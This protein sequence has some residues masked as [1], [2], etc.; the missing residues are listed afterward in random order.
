M[1][2]LIM[3]GGKGGCLA[4]LVADAG[5]HVN[6]TCLCAESRIPS[7]VLPSVPEDALC[8]MRPD[9]LLLEQISNDNLT[10]TLKDLQYP[11]HRRRCRVRNIEVG[12]CIELA[13][14]QK[15]KEKHEKHT[16]LSWNTSGSRG[17]QMCSCTC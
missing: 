9:L 7:Q 8:C 3:K 17:M 12:Y 14:A 11:Q 13:Y 16:E 15:T 10:L 2:R 6:V 5:W 4:L 1:G